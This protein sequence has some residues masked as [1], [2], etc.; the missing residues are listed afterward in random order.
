MLVE[1]LIAHVC[2]GLVGQQ[3]EAC[4]KALEAAGLQSNVTQ[5]IN[6]VEDGTKMYVTAKATTA[7]QSVGIEKEVGATLYLVKVARDKRVEYHLIRNDGI[8]PDVTTGA[9]LTGG[10]LSL[11]WS[12]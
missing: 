6:T 3:Y 1:A 2:A 11:H 5:S 4:H 10:S 8:I 12:F 9:S 7:V